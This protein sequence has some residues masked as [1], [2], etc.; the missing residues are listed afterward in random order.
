MRN[1]PYLVCPLSSEDNSKCSVNTS[2]LDMVVQALWEADVKSQVQGLLGLQSGF[3]AHLDNLPKP[4]LKIK[5]TKSW[6]H[7]SVADCLP[8]MHEALGWGLRITR[9]QT[10]ISDPKVRKLV[11]KDGG[12]ISLLQS[13]IQNG[14]ILGWRDCS[15]VKGTYCSTR[16]LLFNL[17]P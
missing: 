3:K 7:Y 14:C 13:T 9:I 10:W 5:H 6:R 4:C 17:S 12:T 11:T 16:E 1:E 15:V 8:S 2:C